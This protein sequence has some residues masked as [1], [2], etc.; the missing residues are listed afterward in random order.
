M[1]IKSY[2]PIAISAGICL[3]ISIFG[4]QNNL[5]SPNGLNFFGGK[6]AHETEEIEGAI[7]SIYSMRLNEQT[8]TLDPQW[9]Q[10]AIAQADALKVKSRLNKSIVWDNLGPDNVGGRTRGMII[11]RDS[12]NI[13]FVG[14]VSGGLFRS[15]TY[16]QSWTPVNDQQDNLNVTC[17]AQSTDGTIYYGTGEGGFT[18]LSGT[19]NGSPAFIGGGIFKSSNKGGSAFNVLSFAKDNRFQVC[20][21]MVAHPTEN[22]IYIG[23]ET[24]L[25]SI[26][27]GTT[28]K[29][30]S[31]GSTKEIKIDKNGV[32][33]ASNGSGAVYKADAAG[34]MKI[35]NTKANTGGRT[36]IAISP[37]DPNYVYILGASGNGSL[38]GMYRT[39]DGGANWTQLVYGNSVTDIFGP[40][41]QGWYDNVISVIPTNKNKV[42]MGGVDLATWDETNGYLQIGSTFGAPWNTNYVHADKHMIHWNMNTT[43]ATCIIGCDGG[44]YSSQDLS[45]WTSINRG[46]TT[47]QL[48]NVAA[49]SL[50]HV[51]GG[52]Q[53]NGTYLINFKGNAPVGKVSKMGTSIYG[54]DGFDVEFSKFTPSTI[55]MCTYYGTVAR[56][57]NGG[58]SASTFW[59]LRQKGTVQTDFNTTFS[60]FEKS[61]TESKLYLAKDAEVWAAINP[62]DFASEVYWIRVA[63]G[64]GNSRIIEMDYTPDGNHL[65]I[66]KPGA[67]YRVSGLKDADFSLTANPGVNDIP[68]G[69]TQKLISIPG[70]SGRTV[71]SVNVNQN[72]SNHVVV[73][74][75]GYGNSS[76]VFESKNACDVN[77]SWTNITGDLPSMPV[78]DAVIDVDDSRRIIL[79]TDLGVWVTETGG[80][81]WEESNNGMARVPVF[82]IRGYEWKPWEGMSMY[83]GTHGRGYFKS[84]TLLTGTKNIASNK[85]NATVAPNP[86]SDFTQISF[87]AS[88]SG[89][90]ILSVYDLSGKVVLTQNIQIVNGANKAQLNVSGLK[91]GYYLASVSGD[92]N[93][94]A[95]KI[96]V[97]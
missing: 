67:L 59:D 37:E 56:T 7:R 76:Y 23:T 47:L 27:D 69:V 82:E 64:L 92:V 62:T 11:H 29:T 65:F 26:T 86:T 42:I 55:F 96:L 16:G 20:N 39:T 33:W 54:G 40:N 4:F 77:P 57:G 80:S 79:G 25:Y 31:N 84:T 35:M 93:T 48:Y 3:G 94:K 19:R 2:L 89:I 53:D 73:T 34:A 52:S 71:T 90:A 83:I 75:G 63:S 24:G 41:R 32:L 60:L 12:A 87:T 44:I 9:M 1:K 70:A 91:Q 88:K 58:Q 61:A 6:N 74:L 51:V 18:N 97:K 28:L 8:G 30:I 81:K 36:A 21:T 13:W 68:D 49:N 22:K 95:V 66:A 5:K 10:N 85:L 43:P 14:C 45:T 17:M 46:Y 50:G 15:T 38:G 72:D 78:Y